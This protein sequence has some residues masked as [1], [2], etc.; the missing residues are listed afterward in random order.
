MWK[1]QIIL[2][3]QV[4]LR[5]RAPI[6]LRL[7]LG[8]K[9]WTASSYRMR[10]SPSSLKHRLSEGIPLLFFSDC[11]CN[12]ESKDNPVWCDQLYSNLPCW[13]ACAFSTLISVA[14][15][16]CWWEGLDVGWHSDRWRKSRR[17][18]H[19][20]KCFIRSLV[21]SCKGSKNTCYQTL[22]LGSIWAIMAV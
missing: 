13:A 7:R 10:L 14:V 16:L 15:H 6:S 3:H 19:R 2:A 20:G 8:C 9:R 18:G 21:A 5:K 22:L 4:I 12:K 1:G 11:C 17:P